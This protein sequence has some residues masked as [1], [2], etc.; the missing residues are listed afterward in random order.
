M[1]TAIFLVEYNL[2][3]AENMVKIR[4]LKNNNLLAELQL[5]EFLS[6]S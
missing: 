4:R 6:I 5:A 3:E 1:D 2:P